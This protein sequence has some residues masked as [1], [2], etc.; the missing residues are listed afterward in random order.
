[1]PR[2]LQPCG[3]EAAYQRHWRSGQQPC[4]PCRR[5]HNANNRPANVIRDKAI[6]QLIRE[7]RGRFLEIQDALSAEAAR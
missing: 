1:M 5:A 2:E 3:T 4:D 7:H 6:A